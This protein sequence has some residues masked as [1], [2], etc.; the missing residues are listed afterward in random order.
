MTNG[1]RATYIDE[2]TLPFPFCPG[3]GHSTIL[4]ALDAAL[5]ELQIDPH[6][7]VLVTDIGCQGLSDRFFVTNA[8]HGLHG[9]SLTYATGIKLANPDLHVIVLIGDGGCGIGGHH[10]INAARRNI[11]LTVLVFNN[12]NFGMTGGEHSVTTPPGGITTTTRRGNLEQPLDI[13]ATVAVNGAGYVARTTIFDKALPGLIADAIRYDG[14][15][16][17]DIWELC[18]AYYAPA[19]QLKKQSLEETLDRLGFA[20]GVL[21]RNDRPEYS[22]AYRAA[23]QPGPSGLAPQPINPVYEHRLATRQG[24]AIA[25]AAGKRIG[26]AASAFC[27]GAILAGLWATQHNDYPIT[28]RT[29]HSTADVILSLEPVLYMGIDQPDVMLVLFPEGLATRREQIA[30]LDESATLFLAPDL[31]PVETRARVAALD[32]SATGQPKTAWALMALAAALRH[33]G[34]FP[35]EALRDAVA[36]G[37]HA[38]SNLAALDAA[39][40]ATVR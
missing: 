30:A 15:A 37:G 1:T 3:C 9:R 26:S 11:G 12:L 35:V 33:T 38:A 2:S 17:I 4:K 14:F 19:N 7:L 28:V 23:S 31:P 18:T 24:W 39:E 10:L 22:R 32:F 21:Q 36:Q 40:R 16:L 27:R 20:S 13:C 8:F 6:D 5:V 25:G 29:G 34:I